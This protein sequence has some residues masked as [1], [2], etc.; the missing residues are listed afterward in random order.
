MKR[1]IQAV[2]MTSISLATAWAQGGTVQGKITDP[3][4]AAIPM[5]S[6][7]L[8]QKGKVLERVQTDDNGFYRLNV[9]EEGEFE[10]R[11]EARMFG[12]ASTGRFQVSA[13][14]MVTEDL[15]LPLGTLTQSTVVTDTGTPKLEAAATSSVAVLGLDAF[16]DKLDVQD[17]LRTVPGLQLTQTG[18]RGGTTSLFIRG[19]MSDANK[20]VIDG[21]T[22]NDIGGG[23]DFADLA[24][25]GFGKVE[26]YRGPNSILY[27]ADALASV[28]DLSSS[29]ATT[30]LPE[31]EYSVDGGNFGTRRQQ[32]SLGQA[33]RKF[34]YFGDFARFDT[35][36]SLPHSDFSETTAMT[37]AGWQ[38]KD[39]TS[40]RATV[41]RVTASD[42]L[43]NGLSLYAIPDNEIQHNQNTLVSVTLENQT[44][45]KWHNLLRYGATR[46]NS[47]TVQPAAV[48]IPA[49]PFGTGEPTVTL[50]APVTLRGANGYSVS[51]QATYDYLGGYPSQYLTQA[52]QDFVY[53]DSRY[54]FASFLSGLFGFRYANERGSTNSQPYNSVTFAERDNF[55]Y[56]GQLSGNVRSRLFY[57][58]GVGVD[59]NAVFGLAA[60]P[61]ISGAYFVTRPRDR[62]LL[63]GTKV[64]FSYGQ[65]IKEPTITQQIDSLYGVLA[66]LSDGAQLIARNGV[67]P[68]GPER[69]TTFEGG[70]EQ[71]LASSR[72]RIAATFFHNQF[73][74]QMEFVYGPALPQLGVPQ[75]VATEITNSSYGAYVNSLRYRALGTEVEL[76]ARLGSHTMARGGWTYL[77][78]VVQRSFSNDAL[79]PAINPLFPGIPIG[80]YSPL[81]GAR[82]FR[83]APQTGFFSIVYTRRR[84]DVALTGTFVGRRDDSTFLTDAYGGTT[85][86][87]PNRN[88]DAAYQDI[89]FTGSY[90]FSRIVSL[91]ANVDNLLSRHYEQAFGF[92]ATPFNFRVGV[93]FTIGGETWKH[94]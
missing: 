79:T 68:I 52:N 48:G 50:G 87:L 80:L 33:W 27:G 20:V 19:G 4:G 86:I 54:D 39:K 89:G 77:D 51:G 93:R 59:N 42:S 91:Y 34:D 49:D 28:I 43:V 45:D 30:P 60:S 94:L 57:T 61:R 7:E 74:N 84:Y 25:T 73:S 22:A 83:Q 2:W 18:Q 56:T 12:S 1:F 76:E 26:I 10:L 70:V 23:F 55:S 82:P 15:T 40:L 44:T 31:L 6:V 72:V 67:S 29:R 64:R 92:P 62:N 65:G 38:I 14:S 8:V 16:R 85:M 78:A 9:P 37:N 41:R 71:Y 66:G 53:F 21:V 35:D 88:L 17:V 36:N 90:Q 32:A 69:T 11:G 63:S 47:Q 81:V 58:A 24:L 5:A 46:F 13:S 75:E 3:L